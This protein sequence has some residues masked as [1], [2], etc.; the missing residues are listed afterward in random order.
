M[1]AFQKKS[2]TNFL[3]PCSFL[4]C[5]MIFIIVQT[6]A[7][8]DAL[9]IPGKN[10]P[11]TDTPWHISADT[12]TYN[13]KTNVYTATGDVKIYNDD[14]T[15]SAE[16]IRY[17]QDTMD[18]ESTGG[19]HLT[20]GKDTL[21]GDKIIINLKTGIG[22]IFNGSIFIEKSHFFIRGDQIQ[23]TGEDSYTINN[24]S[25]TT[26]DG[27]IP[28][29]QITGKSVD[30]VVEEYGTV[31]HAALWTKKLPVFYFP[32]MTFPLNTKRESGLLAPQMAYSSRNGIEF[33]QPYFWAINQS[34]D[35]TFYYH[36]LQHR[37]EKFGAEYRYAFSNFSKGTLMADTLNDRKVDDGTGNSSQKWGY[38]D[39]A[40]LRKNSDRY[41][42]RAKLNQE[43]P[44]DFIAKLDLDIVSDQ[45]YLEE[46]SSGYTGYDT[47]K[48]Y[49]NSEFGRDI[50][51]QND[52]VRTNSLN[53]NKIWTQY[54]LNA[55]LLWYDD[56]VKRRQSDTDSTLQQLPLITFNALKQ[57]VVDNLLYADMDSEFANF[58]R[59]DGITGQ[60]ID[61][62][63][64]I[65][66]PMHYNNYF[67]F[68][69]SAGFRQTVWYINHTEDDLSGMNEDDYQHREIY[70]LK[71]EISTDLYN[72][73]QMNGNFVNKIKH[74]L[75]P[76]LEYSYIPDMDQTEYPDFDDT[77][78]IEPE[79]IMTFSLTNL[80]ISKS[81]GADELN[82]DTPF[83]NADELSALDSYNQFLWFKVEQSYDFLLEND[84][85][86][87]PFYPL[88]AE[89]NITPVNLLLLHA[90]TE[91]DHD[92]G[93]FSTFNS[94]CKIKNTRKDYVMIEHRYTRDESQSINIDFDS[95]ITDTIRLFGN[96]ERNIEDSEDIEKKLGCLYSAQCWGISL[97]IKDKDD[98]QTIGF[99]VSLKGLAEIGSEL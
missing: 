3:A 59:E 69:P 44:R 95:A 12:I 89:L 87:K 8:S 73:F 92:S 20:V 6:P 72:V 21:M 98:D 33:I 51:D 70:D 37:G 84:A 60:R 13:Q 56:V 47:T 96:Y 5:L 91:W 97:F 85:D 28:P 79:N 35:A 41:W 17:N 57:S 81:Q 61:V 14:K 76:R 48:K 1:T 2:W 19:V 74:T 42:F 26:C 36:H 15:L 27:D 86:E 22:T 25:I 83:K 80:L 31:R 71:A 93:S 66:L 16:S 10:L 64:R 11:Q 68:E 49:F 46:F 9:T 24:C 53:V 29:W 88:Y 34:S 40:Y 39:D 55:E 63:P 38:T 82:S 94:Y 32:Y 50:D 43:L 23:K 62:H 52:S 45:D 18:T 67:T 75:T 4:I 77:D 65:Y 30:L 78:R 90:E 54:S 99:M 58:F 7:I